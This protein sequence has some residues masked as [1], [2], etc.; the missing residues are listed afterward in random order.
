MPALSCY[1]QPP[2]CSPPPTVSA[3][4]LTR[5]QSE[6]ESTKT[7]HPQLLYESKLYKILQGGSACPTR[8]PVLPSLTF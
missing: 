1:A 3:G 2:L 6:Q 8:L 4:L 5:G 7:K